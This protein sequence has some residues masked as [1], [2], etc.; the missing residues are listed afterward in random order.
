MLPFVCGRLLNDQDKACTATIA[1]GYKYTW[2][3]PVRYYNGD[4]SINIFVSTLIQNGH[5]VRDHRGT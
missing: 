1:I 2:F 5:Y 4:S 3:L